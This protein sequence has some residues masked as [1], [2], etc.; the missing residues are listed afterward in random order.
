MLNYDEKEL[1]NYINKL[2]NRRLVSELD[3]IFEISQMDYAPDSIL[4]DFLSDYEYLIMCNIC[5]RFA[6]IINN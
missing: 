3:L 1:G 5:S 2:D 6:H 4:G